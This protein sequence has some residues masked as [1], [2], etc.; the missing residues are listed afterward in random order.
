MPFRSF[1]A[2]ELTPSERYD[3]LVNLVTPRPIA[4][5]ST[6]STDGVP[7]LAPFS[8]FQVG[9]SNPPS[10]MISPTLAKEG[11]EKDTLVNVQST[12]EFV[13]NIVTRAMAEQM[14]STSYTAEPAVSEWQYTCFTPLDSDAVKPSRVNESPAQFECRLF[15]LIRHG[16]GASA[17]NYVIGEVV[18]FHVDE[19]YLDGK[20]PRGEELHTIGRMG[21]DL[22]VDTGVPELFRLARPSTPVARP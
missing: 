9:G 7:N 1:D 3:L 14:N 20:K 10:I 4:L 15:Q 22:Y 12:N 5:V 6:L 16:E 17:A 8:F 19:Q 2:A 13:I 18:R 21:G 11:R